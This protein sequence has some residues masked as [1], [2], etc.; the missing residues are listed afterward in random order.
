MTY[1]FFYIFTLLLIGL[2]IDVFAL[3]NEYFLSIEKTKYIT[4][5][6]IISLVFSSILNITLVLLKSY[7]VNLRK[8]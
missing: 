1:D 3:Y 6:S 8:S 2:L 4:I 7:V 5:S